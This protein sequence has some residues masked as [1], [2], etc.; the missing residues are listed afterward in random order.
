[1]DTIDAPF[2]REIAP[3]VFTHGELESVIRELVPVLSRRM[4][5][6]GICVYRF[7]FLKREMEKLVEYTPDGENLLDKRVI[8]PS[9]GMEH[10]LQET[11]KRFWSASPKEIEHYNSIQYAFFGVKLFELLY[12]EAVSSIHVPLVHGRKG[13]T[14]LTVYSRKRKG[15]YTTQDVTCCLQLR[16]PL[17]FA[18]EE[19]LETGT[20]IRAEGQKRSAPVLEEGMIWCPSLSAQMQKVREDIIA[21][22]AVDSSILILGETGVGK[23]LVANLIHQY[24]RRRGRPWV[25]VNCGGIQETL[26]DSE[27]FGYQKGAFT[28]AQSGQPGCFEL[29]DGGSL[30]LDE[31]GELPLSVQARLLRVLQFKEVKRLG[32]TSTLRLN[33]RIICATHCDLPSMVTERTFREDLW[34]RLNVF[35]IHVPPLREHAEDIPQLA[36]F[37]IRKKGREMGFSNLPQLSAATLALLSGYPW[38]GNIRELENCIERA[39]IRNG[40]RNPELVLELPSGKPSFSRSSSALLQSSTESQSATNLFMSLEECNRQHIRRVLEYTGG[41]I[42]GPNGAAALLEI[43]PST[44]RTRMRKLG[45]LK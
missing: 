4:E 22:A 10:I 9:E 38:P 21:A 29:A 43:N 20:D 33:L 40:G 3:Y 1:M 2:L 15:L 37:F 41:R 26:I 42:S 35:S 5:L 27:L 24:S 39:L 6:S 28:G 11:R 18:F 32:G 45:L 34:F 19:V 31:I 8:V 16:K 14:Y 23:E 44:L 12:G 30:F 13:V 36:S 25:K 17:V 7:F